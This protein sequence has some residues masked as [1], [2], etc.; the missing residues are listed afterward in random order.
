[1]LMRKWKVAFGALAGLVVGSCIGLVGNLPV[2]EWAPLF[3][4]GAFL[5]FLAL[6]REP[7]RWCLFAFLVV[8]PLPMHAF[9]LKLSPLHGGGALGI[10]LMAADLPMLLLYCYWFLDWARKRNGGQRRPNRFIVALIPFLVVSGLSIV[11]SVRPL[12]A[13]CEWLRWIKVLLILIYA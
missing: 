2:K 6:A 3:L 1:M 13:V 8:T 12:W 5:L 11:Y 4:A 7:E 10:Y 9:L